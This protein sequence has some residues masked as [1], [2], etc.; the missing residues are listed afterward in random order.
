MN[1]DPGDVHPAALK[2]D[3]EQNVVGHQPAQRQYIGG[4]EVGPRQKRQTKATDGSE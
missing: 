3:E 2:V 4:E 1:G